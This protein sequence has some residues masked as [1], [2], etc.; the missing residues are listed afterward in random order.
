MTI[1]WGEGHSMF[2]ARVHGER[3]YKSESFGLPHIKR[4]VCV[5]KEQSRRTVWKDSAKRKQIFQSKK[6]KNEST[7]AVNAFLMTSSVFRLKKRSS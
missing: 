5:Y 7:H 4:N 3:I 6:A 1:C 2:F